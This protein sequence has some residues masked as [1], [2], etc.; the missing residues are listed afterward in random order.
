MGGRHRGTSLGAWPAEGFQ[1]GIRPDYHPCSATC[2]LCSLEQVRDLSGLLTG[3]TSELAGGHYQRL[4]SHP[5]IGAD[6][7]RGRKL[8]LRVVERKRKTERLEKSW[9][10]KVA[11]ALGARVKGTGRC[12]G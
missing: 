12:W 3:A 2:Q 4:R 1:L 8:L 11:A 7:S 5:P 10:R 6:L 9:R